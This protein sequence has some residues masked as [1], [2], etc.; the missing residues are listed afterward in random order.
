MPASALTVNERLHYMRMKGRELFRFA[1]SKMEELCERALEKSGCRADQIKLVIPHQSNL[2]IIEAARERMGLP[3][4][5]VAVNIDRYGNTPAASI[6]LAF[7]EAV[8]TGR[9]VPGDLIFMLAF[10]AGVTWGSILFRY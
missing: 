3:P 10:G 2:R 4:E 6:P 1:V 9:I 7:D 8:R 5:K